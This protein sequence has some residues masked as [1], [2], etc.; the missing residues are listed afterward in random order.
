MVLEQIFDFWPRAQAARTQFETRNP[1]DQVRQFAA[2]YVNQKHVLHPFIVLF[3]RILMTFYFTYWNFHVHVT[4]RIHG[5]GIYTNIKGVYW[6]DPCYIM[7]PYIPAPL[8]SYGLLHKPW[9]IGTSMISKTN[10]I[11]WLI[12]C[13]SSMKI[14]SWPPSLLRWLI[15]LPGKRLHSYEKSPSSIGKSTISMGHVQVRNLLIITRG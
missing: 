7:L 5:A 2:W 10:L 11:H 13:G 6:W 15:T 14:G 3:R 12:R 8:G 1:I 9:V 4:H